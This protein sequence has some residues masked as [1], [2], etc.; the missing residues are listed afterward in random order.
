[1][2]CTRVTIFIKI[3]KYHQKSHKI[4]T[5]I[6]CRLPQWTES[7][8]H[9]EIA[10][11][12]MKS[13]FQTNPRTLELAHRPEIG[14]NL[15]HSCKLIAISCI[16]SELKPWNHGFSL[17][18]SKITWNFNSMGPA[19]IDR[20]KIGKNLTH[21]CIANP[22][23]V[24]STWPCQIEQKPARAPY[25]HVSPLYF[26]PHH[27]SNSARFLINMNPTPAKGTIEHVQEEP[28]TKF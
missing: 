24:V 20:P 21:T 1:M 16:S 7:F 9:Q 25:A 18:S 6:E 13:R 11:F 26:I 2:K 15:M 4:S 8:R 19:L 10:A 27:Q 3:I 14:K 22:H 17:K 23:L 12:L 28:Y 5:L